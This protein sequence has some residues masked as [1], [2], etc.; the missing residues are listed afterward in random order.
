VTYLDA[1]LEWHRDRVKHDDRPLGHLMDQARAM[2]PTRR[3]ESALR[4]ASRE[5]GGIAVIAEIKR[6]SPSKGE[7]GPGLVAGTLARAYQ[8]GG[9][10]CLS[11]LTDA[12]HFGGSTADLKEARAATGLPVLRKDFT[13]GAADVADA[14]LMGA[15]AV[16]LIVAALAQSELA[17]FV[18][19]SRELAI[20][21]LV[22]CHDQT[23]VER[24]LAAGATMIGI[25]QRDLITFQVDT[26]RAEKLAAALPGHVLKV[27]E[28]G[29]DG[30]EA[31]RRLAAAGFA[32]VLVGEHL[33]RAADPAAAVRS[34]A[35]RRGAE[36]SGKDTV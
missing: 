6:R 24:A 17:D 26:A 27:A 1:I 33:V 30:P 22:E 34:L 25:N 10:A 20:D 19:I 2:P 32:A 29:V 9:A 21:A 23:E 15:D 13:V 11:I 28:S 4:Y 35:G 7:I 5:S 12:R 31:C 8:S 18:A 3:F 16:L 14:R 36:L